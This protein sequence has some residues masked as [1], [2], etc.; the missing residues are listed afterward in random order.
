MKTTILIL[1]LVLWVFLR[2]RAASAQRKRDAE[3]DAAAERSDP[4]SSPARSAFESLFDEKFDHPEAWP[5]DSFGGDP[6]RESD[7]Q[8][9]RPSS[10]GWGI[11]GDGT[12]RTGKKE[13][14][15][16]PR[17]AAV[18]E[19]PVAAE[20][21]ESGADFDLRQAV[22]YQTI[23]SNKYLDEIYADEN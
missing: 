17:E 18:R 13:K 12:V 21:E 16:K 11:N 5:G 4:G 20:E 14:S 9:K 3:N 19:V 7:G 6:E 22:I 2:S 23:L 10:S 8:A 15:R 1:A